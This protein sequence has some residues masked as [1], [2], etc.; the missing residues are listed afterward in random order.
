MAIDT[1]TKRRSVQAYTF[2]LMRPLPDGAISSGDRA[3]VAWLYSGL[4]YSPAQPAVPVVTPAKKRGGPYPG[5]YAQKYFLPP[6]W[7]KKK[8]SI[9][10]VKKLYVEARAEIPPREQRGLLAA[11]FRTE[12]IS[13]ARLPPVRLV[14]FEALRDDLGALRLLFEALAR[15]EDEQRGLELAAREAEAQ[16]ILKRKREDETIIYLLLM[17]I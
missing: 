17:E 11:R 3:T 16:R 14:D 13:V 9:E 4:S 10:E 2:G 12:G 15:H 8:P 6:G 5:A 1:E 7:K